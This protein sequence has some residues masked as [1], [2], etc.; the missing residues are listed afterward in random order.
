MKKI[1]N[2]DF[3]AFNKAVF[4]PKIRYSLRDIGKIILLSRVTPLSPSLLP[5]K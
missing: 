4:F 3:G 1:G 5:V 2:I